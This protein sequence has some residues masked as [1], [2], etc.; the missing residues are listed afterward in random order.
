MVTLQSLEAIF[1]DSSLSLNM[2]YYDSSYLMKPK[3]S[4]W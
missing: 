4:N 2:S 1:N 3:W